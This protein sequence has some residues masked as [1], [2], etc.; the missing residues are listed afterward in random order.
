MPKDIFTCNHPLFEEPPNDLG[1]SSVGGGDN[2]NGGKTTE[3]EK[4]NAFMICAL[5]KF[6]NDAMIFFKDHHCED[7]GNRERKMFK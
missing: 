2:N 4:M 3:K 7:G 5:T 6:T 1:L